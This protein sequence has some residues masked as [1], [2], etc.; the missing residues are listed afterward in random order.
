MSPSSSPDFIRHMRKLVDHVPS[1]LAYWDRDLRCR[2]ANQAYKTWFGVDPEALLGKTIMELLGPDLYEKNRVHIEAALRG[3]EQTFER[4]VPGPNGTQRHSLANY[5]PDIVDGQVQGFLV[6]VT[7]VTKLKQ[8]EAALVESRRQLRELAATREEGLEQERKM[9]ARE[10]H[11]ELGQLL[12]GLKMDLSVLKLECADKPNAQRV[13]KDMSNVIERTFEVVR[14]VATS[15]RPSVLNIGLIPALEWQAEDFNLRWD[16]PCEFTVSG[17][18]REPDEHRATA[19]FR[20]VQESLTNIVR[21]AHAR[22]ASIDVRFEPECI[23]V[24]IRDDGQGF[25]VR[26]V[27]EPHGFGLLGMEERML[28]IGGQL[29]VESTPNAGTIVSITVPTPVTS[30]IADTPDHQPTGGTPSAMP[31]KK[32]I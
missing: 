26:K 8:T 29:S 18:E 11:D 1:M 23:R 30:V 17:T 10:I 32:S 24:R 20:V 19:I 6:Q 5:I 4:I 3:E 27:K 7:E 22:H 21:H 16:L 9:I 31:D 13:L 14:S 25:D 12:T 28:A 15:L 2:F